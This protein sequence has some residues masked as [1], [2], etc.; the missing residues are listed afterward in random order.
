[1]SVTI[2]YRGRMDDRARLAEM[3]DAAR[4]FCAE[5]RWMWRDVEEEIVAQLRQSAPAGS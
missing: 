1:M 5:Q 2:H 3:L 4:L